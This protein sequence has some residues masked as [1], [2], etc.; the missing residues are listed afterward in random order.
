MK[1]FTL[2]FALVSLF[3]FGSI[4]QDSIPV[5]ETVQS[6]KLT[7]GILHNIFAKEKEA[8]ADIS[9]LIDYS[10]IP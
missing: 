10:A 5:V 3:N 2:L 4:A 7:N 8:A 9:W 1:N 6:V